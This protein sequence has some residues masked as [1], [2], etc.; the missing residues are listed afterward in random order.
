[1][2]LIIPLFFFLFPS[3]L[4]YAQRV[5]D[6]K[7]TIVGSVVDSLSGKTVE[8]PTVILFT[9]SLKMVQSVAGSADGRFTMEA[10]GKGNYF[11]YASQI[12]YISKR[13]ELYLDG[14]QR[15]VDV[16][17]FE[18]REGVNTLNEV[19]ITAVRPLIKNEVDKLTYNLEADPQTSTS[20]VIDILRKVPMLSVD[21]DDNV[22][23]NGETNYKV[24]MNGRSTGMIVKNFK[25]VIKSMPASAIKSIEV[26][27]NPPVKYDSEGI[28]GIINI[29]THSRPGG[30]NGSLNLGANSLG[31]YNGGGYLA[32]QAG[33]FAIS[34]NLYGG[35][36]ISRE[37]SSSS[38]TE[39][40]VS[41]SYRYSSSN[42]KN[43]G[44]SMFYNVGIEA[45][46]EI[47]SLNLITL[48]GWGYL[49]DSKSWGSSLFQ[50]RNSSLELSR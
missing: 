23:L 15:R 12:G 5:D 2:K 17:K 34:T 1:M 31:G 35:K 32:A 46:Y 48:S 40:F 9:D 20:T 38:Q 24:L 47:D 44:R 10:S 14:S 22:R 3:I 36:Y 39:N 8:Y 49:G 43:K 13:K 25:D 27:T 37:S 30:Y 7:I 4:L 42:G 50:A 19:V 41:D 29:I 6:A 26:I 28:G 21:G 45:S 33:K 11:L 16:G 18:I